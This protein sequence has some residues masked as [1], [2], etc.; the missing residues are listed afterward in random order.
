M[1]WSIRLFR[2]LGIEVKVHLTFVL[3]LIWAAYRWG[4]AMRLGP[5]GAVYGMIVILLLFACVTVHE[6]AHSLTAMRFGVKVRGITLLPIGGVA[7]MEEMPKKPKE[8][9]IMSLAGPL[10][11]FAI[12]GLLLL[13]AVPLH[14][15]A[16]L[17]AA[18]LA[19][20]MGTVSWPGLVSYL[21]ISNL[22]IGI[23][24]LLPAYPLDGGRVLR[25]V[26][27]LRMDGPKATVWAVKIGQGMAWILGFLGA[28]GGSWTL[29]IIAV[30]IYLGA[31]QEGRAAELKDVLDGIRVRQAMT[32][33]VETLRLD[34]ALSEAVDKVLSTLQSDFPVLEEG[35]LAGLLT[36][37]DL[38]GGL[39][40]FGPEAAVKQVMRR[41]IETI[42][43]DEPLLEAQRLMGASRVKAIPVMRGGRLE[44]MI[45]SQ[46]VGEA[47]LFLRLN[48]EIL[49]RGT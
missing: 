38:V 9:L 35:R 1:S 34:S 44:G 23:F 26:L 46:D 29:V 5:V 12:A 36:E 30:F 3:I 4:V 40:E 33:K 42:G 6:F 37:D 13:A 41:N 39:R 43:P 7:Q 47:F 32:S 19:R 28:L 11:N 21:A 2:I 49:K 24:N 8:E 45:S 10:T 15:R 17:S 22:F 27:A 14:L 16:G 48:P 20:L 25:S 31:G 18:E